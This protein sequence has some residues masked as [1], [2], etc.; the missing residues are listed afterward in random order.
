MSLKSKNRFKLKNYFNEQ[1][2]IYYNRNN[3]K[4]YIRMK[5]KFN[6]LKI[7]SLKSIIYK[8]HY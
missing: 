5:L 8:I 3:T 7:K 4:K 2:I 1:K 6:K